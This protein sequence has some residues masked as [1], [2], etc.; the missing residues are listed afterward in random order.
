MIRFDSLLVRALAR[1]FDTRYRGQPVRGL[2]LDTAT[3]TAVLAFARESLVVS[4]D[5]ANPCIRCVEGRSGRLDSALPAGLRI[6]GVQSLP[7]ERILT[8]TFEAA[9]AD[10]PRVFFEWLTHRF[11]AI[12]V[13]PDHRVRAVL[14]PHEGERRTL[15][16]GAA[17]RLPEGPARI[18]ADSPLDRTAFL[19]LLESADPGDRAREL[20]RRVAYMSSLNAVPVLGDA[21]H[22]RVPTGLQEAHDRYVAVLQPSDDTACIFDGVDGPQPYPVPLPGTA[23]RST[24]DL[25]AAFAAAQTGAQ[26]ATVEQAITHLERQRARMLA[27][28]RR[29][30]DELTAAPAEAESLRLHAG[31]LLSQ[32]HHAPRGTTTASLDDFEGGE[33]Q[34]SLDPALGPA[35]NAERLFHAARKRERA[36]ARLPAF[37]TR[38]EQEI[39]R[40]S[41]LEEQVRSGEAPPHELMPPSREAPP[42]GQPRALPYRRYQTSSGLEVRV[43]RGARGNDSLTFHHARPDDIWLHARG[44]G[45]AHVVLRWEARDANPPGTD[46]REA[47]VLAA[48]HSQARTSGVVAVDWTRRKYVRKPRKALPGRVMVERVRTIFVEPDATLEDRLRATD[49]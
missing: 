19:D 16:A 3:R 37:V 28:L 44:V 43:G 12:V 34:L 49:V 22:T 42:P 13:G 41:H 23:C 40:L 9:G 6:Q 48:L 32:P 35:E 46:L 21:A 7:D 24:G 10:A 25:L 31:L 47:A 38:L 26:A 8:W 17:Y 27:R 1:A 30:R 14:T 36:A 5:P 15:I 20:I 45:G 2:R 39:E 29:L 18:G 33:V 11:N 4:F